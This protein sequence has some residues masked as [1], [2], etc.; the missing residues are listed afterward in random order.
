MKYMPYINHLFVTN[1]IYD[2]I[3]YIT[4]NIYICMHRHQVWLC[5][6]VL[7]TCN[8]DQEYGTPTNFLCFCMRLLKR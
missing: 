3:D 5:G 7:H 8:C 2:N 6:C 4:L 1:L